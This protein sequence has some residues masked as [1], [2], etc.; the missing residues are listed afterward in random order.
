MKDFFDLCWRQTIFVVKT[1]PKLVCMIILGSLVLS[2]LSWFVLDVVFGLTIGFLFLWKWVFVVLILIFFF[3]DFGITLFINFK[4]MKKFET[5]P[6]T[7]IKAVLEFGLMKKQNKRI[8]EGNKNDFDSWYS[9]CEFKGNL[10]NSITKSIA[11]V[12]K[13]E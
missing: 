10:R 4:L 11:K 2:F 8:R 9:E 7:I 1:I 3:L 6:E 12:V 5:T 13:N